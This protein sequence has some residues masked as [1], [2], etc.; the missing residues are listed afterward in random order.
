MY[1]FILIFFR[2]F[3]LRM[4]IYSLALL[5][6]L[7]VTIA[8]TEKESRGRRH[9]YY[10]SLHFPHSAQYHSNNGPPASSSSRRPP[11]YFESIKK[12][13]RIES[14]PKI[15]SYH[16]LY[17]PEPPAYPHA[18]EP[19]RAA[20]ASYF[21][22]D[23]QEPKP[24]FSGPETIN[25][26]LPSYYPKDEPIKPVSYYPAVPA[27]TVKPALHYPAVPV[28]TKPDYVPAPYSDFPHCP[29]MGGLVSECRLTSECAVWYDLVLNFLPESSC[30]LHD[31][32][33]GTCCPDIPINGN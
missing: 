12:P 8:A 5:C 1:L 10:T 21:P 30:L 20:I 28:T 22:I 16:V 26:I 7:L 15:H 17:D 33:P 29:K 4:D 23:F 11:S 19:I 13:K 14:T 9:Q 24:Y 3:R 18:A 31:G 2:M 32:E 25:P 27:V 6:L